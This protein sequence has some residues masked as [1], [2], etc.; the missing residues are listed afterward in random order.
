MNYNGHHLEQTKSLE[1]IKGRIL[2][3]VTKY[4]DDT[5]NRR[6][7]VLCLN[8]HHRLQFALEG[9]TLV[10]KRESFMGEEKI[11]HL[12]GGTS[13]QV[14]P[15]APVTARIECPSG[16][17]ALVRGLPRKDMIHGFEGTHSNEILKIQA[18]AAKGI[19]RV[20]CGTS[21]F[22]I[23]KTEAG[24]VSVPDTYENPGDYDFS[25]EQSYFWY[26]LADASL[27]PE[28]DGIL[29]VEPGTYELTQVL[30]R[31]Q[32]ATILRVR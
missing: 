22:G 15:E 5:Y 24:L 23:Q 18:F 21:G 9:D 27:F 4:G 20:E 8:C 28:N 3:M 11:I 13:C 6:C 16:K 7:E 26:W 31:G 1:D 2:Y 10:Q 17:L 19:L 25:L 32:G 29:E 14:D 30:Y 12:P